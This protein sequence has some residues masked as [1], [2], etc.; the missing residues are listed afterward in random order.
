MPAERHQASAGT[1]TAPRLDLVAGCNGAGKSTLIHEVLLPRLRSSVYVNADDIARAQWPGEEEARSYEAARVADQARETLL[2]NKRPFITETV[3]S[4]P[5]KL[6]L[7]ERA[8]AKG[9]RVVLHI[10]V[11]PEDLAVER[12]RTRV[13]SGGHSVP[14]EK[15]RARYQRVWPLL[16]QAI[17]RVDRASVYDNSTDETRLIAQFVDGIPITPATWPE[18]TPQPLGQL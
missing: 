12:V 18:W 15:V 9:Y 7:I 6:E 4:H 16:V 14:E 17:G 2:A 10:V 5:S 1:L 8:A 3:F 13:E 11:I